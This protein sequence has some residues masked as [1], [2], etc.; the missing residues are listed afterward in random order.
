MSL[1]PDGGHHYVQL[2]ISLSVDPEFAGLS[3]ARLK[4]VLQPAACQPAACNLARLIFAALQPP[5][6]HLQP[7]AP[8]LHLQPAAPSAGVGG[9]EAWK[10]T[11]SVPSRLC[12]SVKTVGFGTQRHRILRVHFSA[13]HH[14][15]PRADHSPSRGMVCTAMGNDDRRVVA[16]RPHKKNSR[17]VKPIAVK[18]KP[19]ATK[20]RQQKQKPTP[21]MSAAAKGLKE[22]MP[23]THCWKTP[24]DSVL[25]AAASPIPAGRT[26][27]VNSSVGRLSGEAT[28]VASVNSYS[29]SRGAFSTGRPPDRGATVFQT[30]GEGQRISCKGQGRESS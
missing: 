24:E 3:L 14:V 30:S 27:R 29:G 7:V 19:S 16:K 13:R 9:P 6:L 25:T 22:K 20:R 5:A 26:T 17:S 12:L 4:I 21:R 18:K 28:R 10:F 2:M 8:A 15:V 1:G 23:P 11:S